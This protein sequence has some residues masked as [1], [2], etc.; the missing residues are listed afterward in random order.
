MKNFN[1]LLAF[2]LFFTSAFVVAGPYTKADFQDNP[3][4]LGEWVDQTQV[5]ERRLKIVRINETVNND[6]KYGVA[7]KTTSLETGKTTGFEPMYV[8]YLDGNKLRV[9]TEK[10]STNSFRVLKDGRL[11]DN[12]MYLMKKVR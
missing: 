5:F 12:D 11:T 4:F 1:F 10:G 8:G 2:L 9:R 3:K 6:Y 7:L